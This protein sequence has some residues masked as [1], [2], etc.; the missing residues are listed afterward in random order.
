[1]LKPNVQNS[2]HVRIHGKRLIYN[3]DNYRAFTTDNNVLRTHQKN[4]P[5]I[6]DAFRCGR[7]IECGVFRSGHTAVG[8]SNCLGSADRIGQ[9]WC[10]SERFN[11]C[12]TMSSVWGISHRIRVGNRTAGILADT[13]T[14]EAWQGLC[15]LCAAV[16]GVLAGDWAGRGESVGVAVVRQ[17]AV[18]RNVAGEWR[19]L[20]KRGRNNEIELH[21][22]ARDIHW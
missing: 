18:D 10:V 22:N 3:R 17:S 19:F 1:M 14:I 13:T 20:N 9:S 6:D 15:F 5:T 11:S 8:I 2:D 4:V 7:H 12:R 16:D 21:G